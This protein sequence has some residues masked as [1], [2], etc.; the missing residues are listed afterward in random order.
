MNKN[1]IK[2]FFT[3]KHR[4]DAGFT[5]V[6]LIVVI[7]ILAILAGVSVPAY[8]GYIKRAEEA[9]DQLLIAAVNEAFAGGCLEAGI[10][11][12]TVTDAKISVVEQCV[13]GVSSVEGATVA[14][15]TTI[16]NT[17]ELLFE[18]NFATPFKTENV[19]SLDWVPEENSFVMDKVNGVASIVMLSSGVTSIPAETM[20]AISASFIG[21]LTAES[22]G[23][24]FEGIQDGAVDTLMGTVD[25]MVDE[26][27]DKLGGLGGLAFKG[28][29]KALKKVADEDQLGAW[30]ALQ[31]EGFKNEET[32][33]SIFGDRYDYINDTLGSLTASKEEKA[34]AMNEFTNA[35]L[36]YTAGTLGNGKQDAG[37]IQTALIGNYNSDTNLVSTGGNGAKVVSA[38]IRESVYQAYLKTDEGA[39]AYANASGTDAEKKAALTAGEGFATYLESDQC[40]N[41][42]DGLIASMETVQNNKNNIGVNELVQQGMSNEDALKIFGA[43]TTG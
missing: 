3:L 24:M 34:A 33:K 37:T 42:I 7:A 36:L 21:D 30:V 2:K 31:S 10:E 41:D 20:E 14:Q 25:D 8:T 32:K 23:E 19:L 28:T 43:I 11:V 38:A 29:Y 12:G 9:K 1:K 15:F 4:P 16:Y 18:G 40:K 22:L 27:A 26:I 6:E 5:L 17:F 35:M 39:E 13:F